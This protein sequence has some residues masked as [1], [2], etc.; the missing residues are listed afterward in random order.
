[1]QLVLDSHISL[2]YDAVQLLSDTTGSPDKMEN[3]W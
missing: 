1:M 3:E 2:G